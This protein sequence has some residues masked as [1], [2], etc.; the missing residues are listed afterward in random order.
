[1]APTGERG[2]GKFHTCECACVRAP[3]SRCLSAVRVSAARARCLLS[4]R[5]FLHR[6]VQSG[7]PVAISDDRPSY[8]LFLWWTSV[9]ERERDTAEASEGK[10]AGEGEEEMEEGLE[11]LP[12]LPSPLFVLTAVYTYARRT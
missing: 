11:R 1:M 5:P 2:V 4:V 12:L 6:K 7:S 10:E 3:P 9:R 8:A